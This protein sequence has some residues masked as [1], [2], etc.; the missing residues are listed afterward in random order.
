MNTRCVERAPIT[1]DNASLLAVLDKT[2]REIHKN[3]MRLSE[4]R[5]LE[6][7]VMVVPG[8]DAANGT[9]LDGERQRICLDCREVL[10]VLA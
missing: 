6:T 1:R 3:N 2:L 4:C 8:E 10:E 7:G 5:H 9:V